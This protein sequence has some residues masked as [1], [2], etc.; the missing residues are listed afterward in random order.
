MAYYQS[1]SNYV[2][3]KQGY[4][5]IFKDFQENPDITVK[6]KNIVAL[7]VYFKKCVLKPFLGNFSTELYKLLKQNLYRGTVQ[8][9]YF[10][11][12]LL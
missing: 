6:P 3:Q 5:D 1:S 2:L 7:D 8:I 10:L 4:T 12:K 9:Q 11:T